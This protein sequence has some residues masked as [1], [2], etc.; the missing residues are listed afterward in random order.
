MHII[1]SLL[2]LGLSTT[3]LAA[4]QHL[5][6]HGGQI[7]QK[8][9]FETEWVQRDQQGI[10]RSELESWIGTDE[11]RLFIQAHQEKPESAQTHYNI[12]AMYSRLLDDFWDIQFGA[13]YR[14]APDTHA[15]WDAVFGLN[16][17]APYFI[18]TKA[19]VYVAEQQHIGFSLELER[20]FLVTQDWVLQPYLELDTVLH[21]QQTNSKHGIQQSEF[22]LEARYIANK[23]IVPFVKIA[24]QYVYNHQE[25]QHLLYGTGLQLH[26]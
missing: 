6:E 18:E 4:E 8:T 1:K 2:L 16:G 21:S 11:H 7:Y 20:D 22:G 10:W 25:Q 14:E 23:K 19:Y 9:L 26:F 15:T 24:S 3:S 13:R 5:S 12:Q 17:L